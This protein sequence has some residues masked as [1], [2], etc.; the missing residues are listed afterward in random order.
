MSDLVPWLEGRSALVVGPGEAADA[1]AAALRRSGARVVRT[2]LAPVEAP[3]IARA[4][5]VASMVDI[6]VHAGTP[7]G[8]LVAESVT[9][10]QWRSG[11]SADLDSRFLHMAEFARRLI[12]ARER[13]A[14][15]LLQPSPRCVAGRTSILAAHGALDNLVKSLAVEWARDGIRANAIASHVVD[16]FARATSSQQASIGALAAYLVSDHAAYVT[17]MV[18]G[19][20]ED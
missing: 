4:F 1:V 3:E 11:F 20:D 9:L 10:D 14:I 7:I 17:G 8:S 6:L 12:A 5:D 19:I 15:L 18:M 13:G 2:P 16:D